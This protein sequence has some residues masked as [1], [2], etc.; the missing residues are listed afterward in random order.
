MTKLTDRLA[1]IERAV[2]HKNVASRPGPMWWINDP[3]EGTYNWHARTGLLLDTL[4]IEEFEHVASVER[5]A[6][7]VDHVVRVIVDPRDPPPV[8]LSRRTLH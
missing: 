1:R 8:E 7:P 5:G 4:S 6:Y 3:V 2:E